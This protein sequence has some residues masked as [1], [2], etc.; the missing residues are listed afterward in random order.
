MQGVVQASM[1][2]IWVSAKYKYVILISMYKKSKLFKI[3]KQVVE[4][5]MQEYCV[6]AQDTG[7]VQNDR[8]KIMEFL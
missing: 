6:H 7:S 4:I 5:I 8:K 3:N 1:H 2:W